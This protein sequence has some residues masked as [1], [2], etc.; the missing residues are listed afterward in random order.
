MQ[1]RARLEM[2]LI[3]VLKIVKYLKRYICLISVKRAKCGIRS[4]L[5]W[6]TLN[7]SGSI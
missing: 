3:Q 1:S 2:F 7:I 5:C 6:K 4:T